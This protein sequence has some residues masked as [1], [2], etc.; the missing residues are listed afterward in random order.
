MLSTFSFLSIGLGQIGIKFILF[1]TFRICYG[2]RIW[3]IVSKMSTLE[4]IEFWNFFADSAV[5]NISILNTSQSVTPIPLAISFSK[6]NSIRSFRCTYIF[7]SNCDWFF[8]VISR[9]YTKRAIF[10]ILMNKTPEVN[11][12]ARQMTP[13]FS[14]TL[15]ALSA[16]IFHFCISGPSK[17]NS[18]GYL[19]R[20]MLWSAKHIFTCQEWHF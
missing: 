19:I 20:T 15:W 8:T 14:S 18:M 7:C 16:G 2:F 13:F 9:K 3:A 5:L 11:M 12:I 4:N 1:S 6:R 10:D 17:F